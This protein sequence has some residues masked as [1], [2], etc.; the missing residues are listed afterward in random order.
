MAGGVHSGRNARSIGFLAVMAMIAIAYIMALAV[1]HTLTGRDRT[2]GV[3]GVVLG[4]FVCSIP[5]RHFLD[6]LIYWRTERKRFRSR[7]GRAWW[8]V[9]NSMVMLSGWLVIVAGTM[10]FMP[11]R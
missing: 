7:G 4:L 6:L 1:L 9:L 5:A 10:R 3:I 8:V 2:D 11:A